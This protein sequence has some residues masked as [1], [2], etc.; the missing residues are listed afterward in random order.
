MEYEWAVPPD[1]RNATLERLN[2]RP[3]PED[4][5]IYAFYGS[6]ARLTTWSG[7][8]GALP[9]VTFSYGPGDGMVLAASVLGLSINGGGGIPGFAERIRQVDLGQVRHLSLLR[10]A[11]PKIADVLTE[12]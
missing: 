6:S 2:A 7:L 11:I 12:R 5:Q 3:L 9:D 1:G 8:T 10:A 4:V